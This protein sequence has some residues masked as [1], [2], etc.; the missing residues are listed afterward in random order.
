M[1]RKRA[2]YHP[3]GI[4]LFAISALVVNAVASDKPL[5]PITIAGD[6]VPDRVSVIRPL[7]ADVLNQAIRKPAKVKWYA[8]ITI[9]GALREAHLRPLSDGAPL[10][11]Y[12]GDK[13]SEV[14]FKS[15]RRDKRA[16]IALQPGA[17]ISYWALLL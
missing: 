3:A 1:K 11:V 17:A 10:T 7:A 16:D 15:L 12:S 9:S 6:F 4:A 8:A 14:V 13:G 5:P 2:K